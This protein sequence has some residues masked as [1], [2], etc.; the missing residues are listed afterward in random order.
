[1]TVS[2]K[3]LRYIRAHDMFPPGAT[4]SAGV[5]GGADSVCLLFLLYD[6]KAI[7]GITLR[8]IH[9]EHGIRGEESRED[10]DF[11][12]RLCS[13]LDI[14]LR[15]VSADVPAIAK[16]EGLSLEEAGRKVR[17]AAFEEED[18]DRIAVAHHAGDLAETVLFHLF[19]GSSFSGFKGMAPVRG[20]IVRPLLEVSRAEIEEYLN[21]RELVWR[22]DRSNSDNTM[23]RN[24]IRNKILPLAENINSA[25]VRHIA[26]AAED[27]R[28]LENY[29]NAQTERAWERYCEEGDGEITLS[30]LIFREEEEIISSEVVRKCL[31][32]TA[33]GAGDFARVHIS[34]C[35]RLSAGEGRKHLK[36]PR[37][38]V[39]EKRGKQLVFFQE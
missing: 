22:T 25:A 33:G 32:R 31:E 38:V 14:P 17:Y 4:V 36:L 8:A 30:C 7:L 1:M 10:A 5:S 6:L 11:V 34:D 29:L 39:A 27:F 37:R 9:I 35:I 24:L 26:E 16:K 23:A 12:S 28:K 19:R 21:E 20:R 2:E 15:I 18:S 3:V 13:G